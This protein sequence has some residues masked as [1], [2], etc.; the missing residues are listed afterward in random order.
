MDVAGSVRIGSTYAGEDDVDDGN[1]GTVD[2]IDPNNGLIVEGTVGIGKP[3]PNTAYKLDVDGKVQ[4]SSTTTDGGILKIGSGSQTSG[5]AVL[6]NSV[7]GQKNALKI[8]AGNL[9]MNTTNKI[10]N[11]NTPEKDYDAVNKKY[12]DDI[13]STGLVKY[14]NIYDTHEPGM[15]N[16]WK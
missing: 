12:A 16:T 1:G 11:L 4:I 10:I 8:N 5:D 9:D 15:A 13:V 2:I 3:N 7:A 6:I 14:C